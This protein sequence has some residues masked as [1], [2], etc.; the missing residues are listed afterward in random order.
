MFQEPDI[1]NCHDLKIRKNGIYK[2]GSDDNVSNESGRFFYERYCDFDTNELA[3]T[4]I[5]RR[6]TNYHNVTFNQTWQAF[7]LGF[8][9]LD[10][11]FWFGNDFIHKLT[12]ENEMEL[13]I[14]LEDENRQFDWAEYSLFKMK[15]EEDNYEL[16]IEGFRGSAVNSLQYH[17]GQAFSTFDRRNE[18]YDNES[19]AHSI[20]DGWWL[21]K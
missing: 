10:D 17:N 15:S 18:K 2:F 11:E 1:L 9:Q 7:K 8:G 13:R 20:G 16:V 19:C 6:F 4:V 14:V 12:S 3:W 21:K 5:H